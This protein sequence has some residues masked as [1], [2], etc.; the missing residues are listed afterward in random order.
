MVAAGRGRVDSQG[1]HARRAQP[2]VGDDPE[3]IAMSDKLLSDLGLMWACQCG[4]R[5]FNHYTNCTT[6]G[7]VRPPPP[8]KPASK[9]GLPG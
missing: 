9:S 2:G 1:P 4:Q 7:R 6:C 5:V 8:P 3:A